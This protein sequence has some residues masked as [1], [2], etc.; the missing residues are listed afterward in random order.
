MKS[1]R[2]YVFIAILI[3]LILGLVLSFGLTLTRYSYSTPPNI[4]IV[5]DLFDRNA[6]D[7]QTVVSFLIGLEQNNV[8]INNADGTIIADLEVINILDSSVNKS[9][10]S[11]LKG[12][13]YY[14]ICKT[15]NT[16]YLLQWKGLHDIGCGIAYTINGISLPEVEYA[17]LLLPLSNKG[18][19][20]YVSDYETWKTNQLNL[21]D[22]S[23][24]LQ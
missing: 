4:S 1:L 10:D 15:G 22:D 11:L 9:V 8:Y 12:Q 14:H 5:Q 2:I 20:Y 18:W 19:Y 6:N 3:V 17:T 7:I 21:A 16:I 24:G 23:P 13:N